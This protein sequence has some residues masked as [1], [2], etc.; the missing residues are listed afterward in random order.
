[1]RTDNALSATLAQRAM[2]RRAAPERLPKS[3]RTWTPRWRFQ[4]LKNVIDAFTLL[5]DAKPSEYAVCSSGGNQIA[6]RVRI[7]TL[8]GEAVG[9]SRATVITNALARA[10]GL[11]EA[12]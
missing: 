10:L 11:E 1:M 6:A 9:E 7:G 4:P 3:G 12:K 5:D 2:G 8:T